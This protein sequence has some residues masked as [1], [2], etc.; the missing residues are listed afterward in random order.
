MATMSS[1][2][3]LVEQ[4]LSWQPFNLGRI[5]SQAL[6]RVLNAPTTSE[7]VRFATISGTALA[8]AITPA[9]RTVK[10]VEKRMTKRLEKATLAENDWRC[11]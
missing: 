1:P 4:S 8:K 10:M 7:L 5:V 9:A 3:I 2:K 6:L 11:R